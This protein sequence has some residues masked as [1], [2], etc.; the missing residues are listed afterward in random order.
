MGRGDAAARDVGIFRGDE[1]T[2][3]K[4]PRGR[5]LEEEGS[6]RRRGYEPDG[7]VDPSADGS[8]GRRDDEQLARTITRDAH[9]DH[10]GGTDP[11]YPSGAAAHLFAGSRARRDGPA[12][13][14]DDAGGE[15]ASIALPP[16]GQRAAPPPPRVLDS[17]GCGPALAAYDGR[18]L[19]VAR[20]DGVYLYTAD[21]RGGALGF[22]GPKTALAC[23][24]DGLV[25]VAALHEAHRRSEIAIYDVSQRRVAHFSRLPAG[26]GAA[27]LLATRCAK[28][29]EGAP[30]P[31]DDDVPR[32]PPLATLLVAT[33]AGA[34]LRYDEKPTP[35]K[36]DALYKERLYPTAV[37]I[38]MRARLP[39]AG[40]VQV[41]KMH[42]D[43]L[44]GQRDW[45]G[46][47]EQHR[48]PSGG[49][50]SEKDTARA[51]KK[52]ATNGVR[53]LRELARRSS[54]V[55]QNAGARRAVVPRPA[56]KERVPLRPDV[57]TVLRRRTAVLFDGTD[58]LRRYVIR[59]FLDAQKISH[60]AEYLAKAHAPEVA[61]EPPTDGADATT[62]R[63]ELTT[64]LVNCYAKLKDVA[65][66]VS[67]EPNFAVP[68]RCSF[69]VR[70]VKRTCS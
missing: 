32:P 44:H 70:S 26:V 63:P 9:A 21:D 23:L 46:A 2:R 62:T 27:A 43:H 58:D 61:T 7:R 65:A 34:L 49:R 36:L 13:E 67:R 12:D 3:T 19:V 39:A 22:D 28:E 55:L 54:Q 4:R 45:D 1:S 16:P 48:R 60:L 5:R 25:A 14:D 8:R 50:T 69:S 66:R 17:R 29:R 47:V 6:R 20:R 68:S 42:G 51:L 53:T 38:A 30:P 35:E 52:R 64:L 15:I 11:R 56:S 57:C 33:T 40:V 59:K 24:G 18:E 37:Q 31:P 10:H 41:Y